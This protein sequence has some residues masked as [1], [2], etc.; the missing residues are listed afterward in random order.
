MAAVAPPAPP[1]VSKDILQQNFGP[2]AELYVN[3]KFNP[4]M[5]GGYKGC[6]AHQLA[7]EDTLPMNPLT[8][9]WTQNPIK[10]QI[11]KDYNKLGPIQLVLNI[12]PLTT[13]GGSYRR[14]VDFLGH[15]IVQ[16]LRP[17]Y[18]ANELEP[19]ITGDWIHIDDMIWT[20]LKQLNAEQTLIYGPRT[21]ADRQTDCTNA[22]NVYVDLPT[23]WY[24][25]VR[26][27]V[28]ISR[29]G[30]KLTIELI[31][32]ALSNI[33][34]TDGTN[35][36]APLNYIALRKN[37]LNYADSVV[38]TE[39]RISEIPA[40]IQFPF[41]YTERQLANRVSTGSLYANIPL[42]NIL[43]AVS[44]IIFIVRNFADVNTPLANNYSALTLTGAVQ[45]NTFNYSYSSGPLTP[46]MDRNFALKCYNTKYFKDSLGGL[47]ANTGGTDNNNNF[48]FYTWSLKPEDESN[49]WGMQ[50]FASLSNPYLNITFTSALQ[51]DAQVD[52]YARSWNTMVNQ[53]VDIRKLFT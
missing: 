10:F 34:Q 12:G 19:S 22:I 51:A 26:K 44:Y 6:I 39:R 7:I 18:G 47:T 23:Y 2:Q 46:T 24:K 1:R 33:V 40:G 32:N 53:G 17:M 41:L 5:P 48:Y 38:E 20:H 21:S 52:V 35:P 29:L 50:Y 43:G 31:L 27:W 8:S 49:V 13:T 15:F 4:F 25:D 30:N 45:V 16:S 11:E 28:P 36:V 14:F 37:C 42:P 9:T 3:S